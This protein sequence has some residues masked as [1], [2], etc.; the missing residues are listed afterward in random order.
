MYIHIHICASA[1]THIYTHILFQLKKQHSIKIAWNILSHYKMNAKK[2]KKIQVPLCDLHGPRLPFAESF[3]NGSHPRSPPDMPL[4]FLLRC[5][6]LTRFP[7]DWYID[8]SEVVIFS[9]MSLQS[10]MAFLVPMPQFQGSANYSYV[11]L[12]IFLL[13]TPWRINFTF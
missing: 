6:W 7:E 8:F 2:K 9:V 10:L 3:G 5:L 12:L 1:H 11:H 13:Y 4:S